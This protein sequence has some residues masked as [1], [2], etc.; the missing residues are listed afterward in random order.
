MNADLA[1]LALG[2][3][4]SVAGA[5]ANV[6]IQRAARAE[7]ELRA[8]FWSQ[9][10]PGAV[11][12]P[13]CWLAE[14]PPSWPGWTPMVV[15]GFGSAAGYWGMTRAFRLGPLSAIVP[16]VT[17]WS[18]PA[19]LTAAAWRGERP[20]SPPWPRSPRSRRC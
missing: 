10:V 3:T 16:L 20:T 2:F 6:Y 19:M 17:P 7:G 12:L 11:L 5:L 15:T 1:G 13:L 18:V 8:L 14:G 9:A 4:T